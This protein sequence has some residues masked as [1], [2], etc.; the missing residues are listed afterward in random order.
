MK[1][2]FST[3]LSLLILT[4]SLGLSLHD[5]SQLDDLLEHMSYHEKEYGDSLFVFISKHYGELKAAHQNTDDQEKTEHEQLP[6]QHH[7]HICSIPAFILSQPLETLTPIE[8]FEF[9]THNFVYEEPS[10][11][12]FA[13]GL[14]QPPRQS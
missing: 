5:M 9:K 2:L 3:I 8:I 12:H 6:F 7:S 11:S 13:E 4:Q 14:F 1:T 10:S